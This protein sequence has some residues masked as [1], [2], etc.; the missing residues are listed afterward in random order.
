[1]PELPPTNRARCASDS[2]STLAIITDPSQANAF[3]SIHGGVIL[4]LADECGALAAFRHSGGPMVTTA[5][6]DGFTFI[7]PVRVGERVELI[8]EITFVGRT[9]MEARIDVYAESMAHP[10]PRLVGSG[11]GVYVALDDER[12]PR[13]VPALLSETEA[14][15]ERDR[16]AKERQAARLRRREAEKARGC[17]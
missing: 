8:A 11:Y 17:H 6:I 7:D 16:D 5:A 2:R 9:S 15:L 14:H 4:R 12:K 1:M 10:D 13:P 3:G